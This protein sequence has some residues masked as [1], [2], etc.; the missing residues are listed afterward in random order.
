MICH[1]VCLFFSFFD[2]Q[3]EEFWFFRFRWHSDHWFGRG[4][5]QRW[6][7]LTGTTGTTGTMHDWWQGRVDSSPRENMSFPCLGQDKPPIFMG[8]ACWARA[9][10]WQP[11]EAPWHSR[12]ITYLQ[13][14]TCITYYA[15]SIVAWG[16]VVVFTCTSPISLTATGTDSTCF[17]LASEALSEY[18][19]I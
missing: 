14:V 8:L 2:V 4:R 18:V 11:L 9:G 17:N 12:F 19:R 1:D 16:F 13:L 5:L 3:P 15:S 10:L 6:Y 7:S